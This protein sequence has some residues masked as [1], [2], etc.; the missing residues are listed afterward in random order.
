MAFPGSSTY[1]VK[2]VL[3]PDTFEISATPTGSV[4]SFSGSPSGQ[5][6]MVSLPKTAASIYT[7]IKNVVQAALSAGTAKVFVGTVLPRIGTECLTS[8]R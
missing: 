7:G 3:S 6:R 1:W 5:R 8:T 2:N 4:I